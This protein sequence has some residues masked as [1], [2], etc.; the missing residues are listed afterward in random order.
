MGDF[1]RQ[2]RTGQVSE[3]LISN[4]SNISR[5]IR[6]AEQL[7]ELGADGEW[8]SSAP[9]F[10]LENAANGVTIEQVLGLD[11]PPSGWPWWCQK[12]H[13]Q[14]R[15]AVGRLSNRLPAAR[16]KSRAG[17]FRKTIDDYRHSRSNAVRITSD[18]AEAMGT[19]IAVNRSEVLSVK[20]IQRLLDQLDTSDPI[21]VQ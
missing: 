4:V 21:A 8:L 6:L 13:A 15:D 16:G 18:D 3:G 17:D 11:A 10:Y 12:E 1:D 20:T 9:N 19:L 7:P 2:L 5:L 14:P